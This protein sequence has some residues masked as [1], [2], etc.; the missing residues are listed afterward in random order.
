MYL[1]K[2][3][4]IIMLLSKIFY[5][6]TVSFLA[7][8]NV[9]IAA[10]YDFG[11]LSASSHGTSS[12]QYNVDN[13]AIKS[14]MSFDYFS[15]GPTKGEL[16]NENTNGNH[17]ASGSY[18]GIVKVNEFIRWDLMKRNDNSKYMPITSPVPEPE[19]YAMIL[20]GLAL[21]G[22]TARRRKQN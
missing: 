20:A 19:T 22:L 18:I 16:L 10:V 2:H 21:I 3:W 7:F 9:A 13:D 8:A 11:N 4:E 14:S 5:L 17:L 12:I 15:T 6:L 1:L